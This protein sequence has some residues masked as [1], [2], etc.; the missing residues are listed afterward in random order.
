MLLDAHVWL[1]ESELLE[2]R[3]ELLRIT[4]PLLD[5]EGGSRAASGSELLFALEYKTEHREKLFRLCRLA[6]SDSAA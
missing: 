6:L 1:N 5:L 4:L 2:P 3:L